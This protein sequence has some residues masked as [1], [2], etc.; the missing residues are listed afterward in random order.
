MNKMNQIVYWMRIFSFVGKS[1]PERGFVFLPV[2]TID[3][4]DWSFEREDMQLNDITETN[5]PKIPKM[6]SALILKHRYEKWR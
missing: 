4:F 5:T 6:F 3:V 1:F 2:F